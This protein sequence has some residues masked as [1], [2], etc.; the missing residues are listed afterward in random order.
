MKFI[1][2][3]LMPQSQQH[4]GPL[5]HL[6]C[7]VV[8]RF[9]L[10]FIW[11]IKRK[12]LS[13][14]WLFRKHLL[15]PSEMEIRINKSYSFLL[16][17]SSPELKSYYELNILSLYDCALSPRLCIIASPTFPTLWEAEQASP[18]FEERRSFIN[19]RLQASAK[20]RITWSILLLKPTLIWW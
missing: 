5:W 10:K 16:S 17:L 11:I 19:I 13:D 1:L 6:I 15:K 2:T 12:V 4:F 8:H 14:L 20:F 7:L 9:E 18:T 3:W